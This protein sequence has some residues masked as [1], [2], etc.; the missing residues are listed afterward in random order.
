MKKTAER[1]KETQMIMTMIHDNPENSLSEKSKDLMMN[2]MLLN[3]MAIENESGEHT[4]RE[5]MEPEVFVVKYGMGLNGLLLA[6]QKNYRHIALY[7][8]STWKE[9]VVLSIP[10]L[11]QR[12]LYIEA[13]GLQTHGGALNWDMNGSGSSSPKLTHIMGIK[14]QEGYEANTVVIFHRDW[15]LMSDE[16]K[17]VRIKVE[18]EK[19]SK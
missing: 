13:S 11:V 14:V 8:P 10:G 6:I 15:E 9:N 5:M 7:G 4:L 1:L 2:T 3:Q 17:P 19:S 16:M 12:M 18:M